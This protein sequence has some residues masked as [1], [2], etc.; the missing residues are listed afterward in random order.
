MDQTITSQN[1][2]DDLASYC[3]DELLAGVAQLAPILYDELKRTAHR[4]RIKLFSPNTL[5][6]TA[7]IHEA[8]LKLHEQP[9]FRSHSEFL[10]ISAV[11]MRHLLIDRV[12]AQQAAKRGGGMERVQMA[13]IKDLSIDNED[14]VC[15]VHEALAQLAQF[16]P[17]LVQVVECRYFAGYSDKDIAEALQVTERTVR[18]DWVAAK[19]WLVKEL[20]PDLVGQ[21]EPDSPSP[22]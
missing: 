3:P 17:R 18:R 2:S 7:L 14:T 19:A 11:T 12:R 8:F 6:T 9:G 1:A 10:R 22:E 15:A 13:E 4:Q 20:G 21:M 5:H 16:A